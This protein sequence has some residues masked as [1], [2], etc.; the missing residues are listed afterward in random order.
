MPA[1]AKAKGKPKGRGRPP[2]PEGPKRTL[3]SFK[4]SPEFAE[5]LD[6]LT[7]HA[8]LTVSA[9]MEHALIDYAKKVGYDADPPE[10]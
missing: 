6:G 5:W 2:K 1:M 3:A 8:R 7:A 9:I 10:R 4:G